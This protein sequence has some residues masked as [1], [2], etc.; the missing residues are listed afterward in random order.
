MRPDEHEGQCDCGTHLDWQIQAR[1]FTDTERNEGAEPGTDTNP[2]G[3]GPEP[4]LSE[5]DPES[6]TTEEYHDSQTSPT[7]RRRRLRRVPTQYKMHTRGDHSRCTPQNCKWV[8]DLAAQGGDN[9]Q[10]DY[11]HAVINHQ[12]DR[13]VTRTKYEHAVSNYRLNNSGNGSEQSTPIVGC[14][15]DL[16]DYEH[17]VNNYQLNKNVTRTEYEHAVINY[18]L[19]NPVLRKSRQRG[20]NQ[21]R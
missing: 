21:N 17:A 8:Y 10:P 12:L 5:Y 16:P 19:N 14:D 3:L 9:D 1:Q 6:D 4:A 18:R 2:H 11:E 13:S 15:K 7:L 20:C